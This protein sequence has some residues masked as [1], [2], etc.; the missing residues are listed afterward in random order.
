MGEVGKHIA[1][2]LASENHNVTIVDSNPRAIAAAEERMDVMALVG[3]AGSVKCLKK[4]EA[5]KADLVIAVTD[6]DEANMLAAY[7]AKS[8]GSKKAIARVSSREYLEGEAGVYHNLLNVDLVISPPVL[9][10]FEISKLIRSVGA[11][12]V[13][14]FAQNRVEL[15]QL[16]LNE[17][18][19]AV[20]MRLA[21]L[22]LPKDTLIAAITRDDRLIIPSG[23][24]ELLL[25]D[26][27]MAIGK[28]ES[29]TEVE[30]FFDKKLR[31]AARKVVIVGGGEI[32]LSVASSFRGEEINITL[33]DKDPERCKVLSEKL[34]N[35]LLIHGDGTD[36]AILEEVKVSECDVFVSAVSEGEEVNLLAGLL[37][38]RLGARKSVVLADKPH[39][40]E[41]YEQIGID[42]VVS[43]RL[44]AANQI[45]KYV[46]AGAVVSVT[47]L[48]EGKA[49][50]LEIVVPPT[51]RITKKP[52][53]DLGFP[54]GAVIGAVAG[55]Q[56]VMVPRGDDTIPPNSTA[57]VF[58]TPQARKKVERLFKVGKS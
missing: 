42:A 4:A 57:I 38:K 8:L 47:I 54:R 29:I 24:D 26:E 34:D 5:D 58:T 37:A 7:S 32:G 9:S 48:E 33:I 25:N 3:Q 14:N 56:G 16:A 19:K 12:F 45:M 30:K 41:L 2:Y 31:G 21:D 22:S 40:K 36:T 20:G 50:I 11:V 39:Y 10:A 28:V 52:L 17:Q 15:I 23:D 27:V 35:V 43:P 46:R 13:E 51:A 44:V 49:E 55:P 18:L 6:D 53:K 1:G